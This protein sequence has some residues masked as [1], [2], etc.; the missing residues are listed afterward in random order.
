MESRCANCSIC[1]H[2]L[3]KPDTL[4]GRLWK[5]HTTWC[6]FWKRYEKELAEQEAQR[7]AAEDKKT[8]ET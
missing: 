6:P 7:Q 1:Q 8:D 2:F 5:W 4:L 3:K